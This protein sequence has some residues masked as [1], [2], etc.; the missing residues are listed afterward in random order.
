MSEPVFDKKA[1]I[2]FHGPKLH[3][4]GPW[5]AQEIWDDGRK[6]KYRYV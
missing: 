5:C 4:V 1:V 2:M 3:M 6:G